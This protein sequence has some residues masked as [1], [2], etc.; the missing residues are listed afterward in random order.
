MTQRLFVPSPI[1]GRH[2][3]L[4]GAEAHHLLD[5]MRA[6]PGS[7]WILF[8]GSGSEFRARLQAA[9]RR[10]AELEVL[11]E[12]PINRETPFP[13]HLAVALPKGDRQKWLIEK[14]VELGVHSLTPLETARSVVRASENSLEKLRRQVIEASKQCGRNVLMQVHCTQSFEQLIAN[15]RHAIRWVAEPGGTW[16]GN[17]QVPRPTPM[18]VVIGPE[19]GFTDGELASA[20]SHDWTLVSWGP[21]VMRI[22]TAA[23]AVAAF[24]STRA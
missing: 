8:D 10:T 14:C 18:M 9:D 3:K 1:E 21:R 19:G 11:Q 6:Q 17:L 2:V 23:L 13:L 22:E 4:A 12:S 20:Q 16:I 15:D 5:V 24:F 7:E